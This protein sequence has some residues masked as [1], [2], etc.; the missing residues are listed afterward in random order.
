MKVYG[1]KYREKGN[2]NYIS[3]LFLCQDEQQ[4]KVD[5]EKYIDENFIDLDRRTVSWTGNSIPL[6]TQGSPLQIDA[7]L[8]TLT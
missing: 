5:F 1:L 6:L 3:V 2:K 8:D 4:L 7:N